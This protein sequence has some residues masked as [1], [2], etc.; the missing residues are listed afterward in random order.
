MNILETID[1]LSKEQL[2]KA[3]CMLNSWEWP[4]E[5]LHLK[6]T[7]WEELTTREMYE[8]P[9]HSLLIEKITRKLTHYERS[10]AWW[11]HGLKRTVEE[12]NEWYSG[13]SKKQEA[14]V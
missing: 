10:Q 3:Y 9:M 4:P 1:T 11:V 14:T 12:H 7:G 5:F 2:S 6:P 13:W 8:H